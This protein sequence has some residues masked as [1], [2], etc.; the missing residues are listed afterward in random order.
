[1][2]GGNVLMADSER[3]AFNI[4]RHEHSRRYHKLPAIP[5]S[6]VGRDQQPPAIIGTSDLLKSVVSS[7]TGLPAECRRDVKTLH[8]THIDSAMI[9]TWLVSSGIETRSHVS[10]T[11]LV[12]FVTVF[13][14][15]AVDTVSPCAVDWFLTRSIDTRFMRPAP[16][17]GCKRGPR[18]RGTFRISMQTNPW[19]VPGP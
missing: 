10:T 17:D 9:G 13:F 15:G 8:M 7:A 19:R 1:M 12:K 4:G 14:A 11:L 2:I 18:F 5:P 6:A 3:V 16:Q